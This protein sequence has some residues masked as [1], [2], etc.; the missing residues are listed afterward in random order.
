MSTHAIGRYWRGEGPLWKVYWLW[1]V[2]GSW[3]LALAFWALRAALGD[4]HTFLIL[5]ALVMVPYTAWILVSV[6]RCA[7][8]VKNEN[9]GHI[10]RL[11]TIVWAL[12]VILVGIFLFFDLLR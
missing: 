7:F 11:L 6:W 5:G 10:A 8:N 9:Y 12:N 3:L 1:G 2:A 4:G